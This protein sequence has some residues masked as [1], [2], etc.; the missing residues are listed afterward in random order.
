MS[1]YFFM[2][3]MPA[4]ALGRVQ[5]APFISLPVD[6]FNRLNR[7]AVA[8]DADDF[9][10]EWKVFVTKLGETPELPEE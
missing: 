10:S 7:R 4:D 1:P 9:A 6:Q 3:S 2:H 5:A 8:A